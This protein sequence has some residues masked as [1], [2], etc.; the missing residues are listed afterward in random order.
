MPPSI[1]LRCSSSDAGAD[2]QVAR[3]TRSRRPSLGSRCALAL[4][5][6]GVLLATARPAHV[7]AQAGSAGTGVLVGRVLDARTSQAVEHS[8]VTLEPAPGGLVLDAASATALV[9]VRSQLTGESGAY[10]FADV[11]PGSY[12]LRV[13]R[14][15]YRATVIEIEVR[16]RGEAGVSVA[17]ELDP[18]LLEPV[19]VAQRSASYFVPGSSGAAA[20]DAA[21]VAAEHLRQQ[22]FL[23]PDTRVLTYG[24]VVD[25]VTFGEA[26]VFRALQRIP[27]VGTRD[28]YSA[29]L[30]TRGAPWPHTRVTFDGVPLFNPVHAVGVLSAIA[31]EA[32]GTVFFHP[33]VRP[34]ALG[35]GAAA[36][37]DLR[38]RAG[39]GS[40]SVRGIADLSMASAKLA[41]D[42]N[43]G[44]RFAWVVTARRSHLDVLRGGLGWLGLDTLDLPFVFHDVT[45]RVDADLGAGLQLESSGLWEEDRLTGDVAGLLE[46][47]TARW[48]NTAGRITLRGG[49]QGVDASHT[50]GISRFGVRTVAQRVRGAA[51]AWTEPAS[52]N[53]M[54][55][56]QLGGEL[57][58]ATLGGPARWTIGYQIAW[59]DID[60]DG[61]APRVHAV[62]PDTLQRVAYARSLRIAAVH[63]DARFQL[64]PR[65]I[66]N[67][68]VRLEHGGDLP[69]PPLRAAP[70]VAA[71]VTLSPAQSVSVA[72][73]RSWQHVQ[74]LALAGPSIHPAFH[75]SHF[76]L[77]ADGQ[78]PA[79]RADIV[80]IGSERWLGGGWLASATAFARRS[81]G[82][83][84]PDP[85]PGRLEG[86]PSSV[87]GENAARGVELGAR[88]IG[89]RWTSAFAYAYAS[90][91]I[92]AAGRRYPSSADRRELIDAMGALRLPAGFRIAASFTAMSGA[93]FTRAYS[94]SAADCQ[95]FGFG[96]D[97]PSGS[98]AE[99]P[100][101]QRTPPYRS[102]DTV[103]HWGR[104]IRDVEVSAYL[105]VRNVLARDNASTYSGSSPI[106]RIQTATGTGVL[107]D[108]RFERGLPRLPLVGI[109]V[110]F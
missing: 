56:V 94:R 28:D 76:W 32:L 90:S 17:L 102:L 43:V 74:A 100:N 24:D 88:R 26:D 57:A 23:A 62:K 29:E 58:P 16:R 64:G 75:A 51:R 4:L 33:G 49:W 12:R 1:P 7:R 45:A 83:V 68:G 19:R 60:Y 107:W 78:T 63:G 80:S 21:R 36:V 9:A 20:A 66:L 59:Q 34:A 30:W 95:S 89:A 71:R 65:V 101:A 87:V 105:Q 110:A 27:G 44:G 5:L 41:L 98:W 50:V 84:V 69:G 38:T 14:L 42:Q 96:C 48:G 13:E 73:G 31:P 104:G 97:N 106:A 53:D 86:R 91:N 2:R 72:A 55:H 6:A 79:L 10:R 15:G 70:R 82:V 54:H 39:G 61:P 46:R 77:W 108:D 3:T 52:R 85:A 99:E 8:L 103:V 37:V 25:G 35:E 67:P 93:P 22:L 11:A 40:G 92:T 18:V 109:R 47:T 81:T